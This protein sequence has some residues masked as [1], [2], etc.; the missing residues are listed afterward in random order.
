MRTLDIIAF[1][2]QVFL[3]IGMAYEGFK[4]PSPYLF[5]GALGWFVAACYKLGQINTRT[6]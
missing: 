6:E 5:V 2:F 4:T 1:V 3:M